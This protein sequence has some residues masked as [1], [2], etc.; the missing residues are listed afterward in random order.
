MNPIDVIAAAP[1]WS[2][3][4]LA[5]VANLVVFAA[6]VLVAVAIVVDF[7][8][9]HRQ[10]RGVVVSDRSLV[11]TGSMTAF[12]V[13]YYLVIRLGLVD[14]G[15]AGRLRVVLV[16]IGL[17][18]I[19][20]GAAVNVWGRLSLKSAWAN[21]IKIYEGHELVTGGPYRFVRHPLYASLIWIF[22]GGS[23]VYAEPI[24]LVLTLGIFVPMM[25]VRA[26]KEDVA[27][28][29]TFGDEFREYRRHTGMLFPGTGGARWRT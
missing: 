16:V 27:L 7:R 2:Q 8:R 6:G 14:L 5:V 3:P 18:A 12:F 1:L 9:Y 21:Q 28:E 25:Y 4:P 24:S 22:I 15:L 11:E 20:A 26:R 13:C 23:L 19:V 10:P 17:A 29:A